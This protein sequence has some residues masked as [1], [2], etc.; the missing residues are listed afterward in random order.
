MDLL[1]QAAIRLFVS[2]GYRSTNL[3]QISGAAQLTKGAVYFYFGSKEAVLL[4]LLRRVQDVVVDRAIAAVAQASGTATDKLVAYVHYQA[5]LGIT[6]RDEV[7]LLI[8]MSL[9][10]KERDGEV[11]AFIRELYARQRSFIDRLIAA[12]QKSGEFRNDVPVREMS[13]IVQALDDG[14]FLEWFRRSD[15]LSG[16]D[17]TRGLRTTMLNGILAQP[18]VLERPK[19]APA[20][21]TPKKSA[22]RR[23]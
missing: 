4:E 15:H 2:Q 20:A 12:G 1:L 19:R 10:F 21:K 17:L 8:L 5:S 13:A 18:Q 3:E 11:Q 22:A 9:E 23:T 7:L 16:A 14:T 6:H